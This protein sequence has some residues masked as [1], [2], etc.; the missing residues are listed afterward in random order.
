MGIGKQIYESKSQN[1][2]QEILESKQE[3]YPEA[4]S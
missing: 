2:E 4:R 3:S 1:N